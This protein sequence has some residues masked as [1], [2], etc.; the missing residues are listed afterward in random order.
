MKEFAQA[1]APF[2]ALFSLISAA[3]KGVRRSGL[4]VIVGERR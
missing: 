3:A 4:L 1:L 2:A